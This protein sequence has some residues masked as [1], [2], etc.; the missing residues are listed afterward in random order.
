MPDNALPSFLPETQDTLSISKRQCLIAAENAHLHS[1]ILIEKAR[2][3][4][5]EHALSISEHALADVQRISRAGCWYCDVRTQTVEA[6]VEFFRI[7]ERPFE[8]HLD[9]ARF[10]EKVHPE[11]RALFELR[12]LDAIAKRDV[13]THEYRIVVG[14]GRIKHLL[15][16]GHPDD[17]DPGCLAYVGVVI[18]RTE[19]RQTME[20]LEA[21]Q[22]ELNRSLR[23]ATMGELAA[24]IIH[25]VNQP[26]TAVVTNSETCLRWLS[27]SI[28]NIEQARRAA[29]RTTRD[30]ER[31]GDVVKGLKSR[32]W[33]SVFTRV[34]VDI[35]NAIQ[36]VALLLRSDLERHRVSLD[37]LLDAGRPVYGDR[38]QLQQVLINLVRNSI[39]AMAPV[40][41]RGRHLRVTSIAH[42]DTAACVTVRDNGVG[43]CPK[44][45][46]HI[47]EPM[48]TT[49]KD[50]MGM[51]LSISKSIIEAHGGELVCTSNEEEGVSF[52]FS[53]PYFVP[54]P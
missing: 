26:L 25:E 8:S 24:S 27:R 20:A 29:Q 37:L 41:D 43:L 34:P 52:L 13:L 4:R 28:P 44:L 48:F 51:G 47:Y 14:E 38:G 49:K 35:D 40:N 18:D 45:I 19:R 33:K 53:V 10:F 1:Q 42:A 16:E 12:F 6:S 15:I 5:A 46:D 2:R 32:A 36:E 23:F 7:Q 30:A 31:I 9:H 17:N 3:E 39:E 54:A 50:G 21:S 11:D 22:T